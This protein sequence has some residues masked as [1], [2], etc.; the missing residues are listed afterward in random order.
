[1]AYMSQEHKKEL[2]PAIKAICKKY[3]VKATLGVKHYSTLVLNIKSSK[4][5]FLEGTDREYI[6]VN[7]YQIKNHYEGVARDFLIEVKEAMMVDNF[8]ES[9]MMTDYFHV[10]WH[11][12]INIG[13]WNKPYIVTS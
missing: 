1:M 7:G 4:I 11:I 12:D 5:D 9:D 10:G 2:A 6:Q 13:K 8:D 3:N